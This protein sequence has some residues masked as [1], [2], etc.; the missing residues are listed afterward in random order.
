ME[1]QE[2]GLPTDTNLIPLRRPEPCPDDSDDEPK[3]IIASDEEKDIQFG[4]KLLSAHSF[5]WKNS[6]SEETK[7]FHKRLVACFIIFGVTVF[8]LLL[9]WFI[10][11][12]MPK[13]GNRTVELTSQRIERSV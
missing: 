7:I 12:I 6:G 11:S 2:T 8:L 4:L 5:E 13:K 1:S 9:L 3:D 10:A